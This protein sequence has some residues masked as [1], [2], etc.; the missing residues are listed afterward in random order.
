MGDFIAAEGHL[1][2]TNKGEL[3]VECSALRLLSKS[4]RP[5]PDKFHGLSD[6]ETKYRQRYVDLI[7]SPDTRATFISRSKAIA[8]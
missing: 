8:S 2:K 5:L 6:L 7:V 4:L 1:F 3:S